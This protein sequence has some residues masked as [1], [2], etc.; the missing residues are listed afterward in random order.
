MSERGSGRNQTPYQVVERSPAG[1]L[2]FRL[3]PCQTV[4]FALLLG[5]FCAGEP[6]AQQ[7]V[8]T[9][10]QLAREIDAK[11]GAMQERATPDS[12][13][14]IATSLSEQLEEFKQ[15]SVMIFGERRRRVEEKLRQLQGTIGNW[16]VIS[17]ADPVKAAAAVT[18]ARKTWAAI[19][20]HY[21]E[22]ALQ[23]LPALWSCP[24]HQELMKP[25]AGN[26]PI[27]GMAL[28]PIYVTQPQ[29]TQTSII[30]AQI[31]AQAPLQIAKR[32]DLRIRLFFNKDGRPVRLDDLEE[33]HTRKI[34]LLISDIS[35]TDYH[36]EHPEQVGE[37][38]YAFSFTP[39]RPDTYRVW[40]DLKPVLTHVQQYSVADIPST[41]PRQGALAPQEPENRHAEIEGYKFDL[42]FVKPLIHEKETV[43]GTLR[44]TGPD[45][46]PF[47]KLEVVMGAFGHFVGICDDFS[48]VLHIHTV[49]SLI[50]S[51]DLRGGPD[52]PIYFRSNKPGFVRFFGQVKIRGKE[53]FPRFVIR[54]QPLQHLPSL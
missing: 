53:M 5:S 2:N 44:V 26:C 47:N 48:T 24:M 18:D 46:E 12:A 19:K 21:P 39:A 6:L 45:G 10:A 11:V 16:R 36:H 31:V 25:A 40:A 4:L 29:L 7:P 14:G 33:T 50:Q 37:G 22:E 27:C 3:L 42:T 32:A 43:P 15:Q 38:E 13:A 20:A 8:K 9:V 41:T 51:P 49:G 35:Q 30:R 23:V 52:L 34:H 28:E 1:I 17:S 54:V